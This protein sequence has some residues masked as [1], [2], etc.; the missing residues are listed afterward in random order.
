LRIRSS[1]SG[2]SFYQGLIKAYLDKEQS[3]AAEEF[4]VDVDKFRAAMKKPDLPV[5]TIRQGLRNNL[6]NMTD[7][8]GNELWER[9]Q[10]STAGLGC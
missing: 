4:K 3:G 7:D 5:A 10:A 6:H 2:F 1:S 9:I 8:D